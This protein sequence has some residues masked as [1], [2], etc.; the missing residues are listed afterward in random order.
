MKIKTVPLLIILSQGIIAGCS[1]SKDLV[2]NSIEIN[3]S[4]ETSENKMMLLNIVRAY[5]HSPKYYSNFSKFSGELSSADANL[6]V[7]FPFVRKEV[8]PK[9]FQPSVGYRSGVSFDIGI[10]QSQEFLRGYLNPVGARTLK[11]YFDMGWPKSMLLNMFV[12]QIKYFSWHEDSSGKFRLA[13][14]SVLSNEPLKGKENFE[15]FNNEINRLVAD[16]LDVVYIQSGKE[17]NIAGGRKKEAEGGQVSDGAAFV[18]L[19]PPIGGNTTSYTFANHYTLALYP[20]IAEDPVSENEN[21]I[22]SDK[23]SRKRKLAILYLRSPSSIMNYLGDVVR[24]QLSGDRTPAHEKYCPSVFIDND[25]GNAPL[26]VVR[27]VESGSNEA[28]KVSIEYDGMTYIIPKDSNDI[29][30]KNSAVPET[31]SGTLDSQ[32]PKT[33]EVMILMTQLINQLKSSADLQTTPSVRALR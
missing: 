1:A 11:F 15:R 10:L 33:M 5:R 20:E 28:S 29:P 7:V 4:I 19:L 31:S 24:V 32:A 17:Q 8:Y 14:N 23:S 2:A 18:R 30:S 16:G 26:F 6:G 9:I 21:L 3:K 12:S 27:E 25:T 13:L 22:Y